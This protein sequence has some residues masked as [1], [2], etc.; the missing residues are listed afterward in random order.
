MCVFQSAPGLSLPTD[1]E[2][3]IERVQLTPAV[4]PPAPGPSSFATR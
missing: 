2:S 4:E 3:M 1:W